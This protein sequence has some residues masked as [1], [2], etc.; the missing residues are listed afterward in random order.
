MV[1]WGLHLGS[2]SGPVLICL[3]LYPP[4]EE[5]SQGSTGLR[6]LLLYAAIP[7]AVVSF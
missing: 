7:G 4:Q 2:L 1:W 6:R 5:H 3:K